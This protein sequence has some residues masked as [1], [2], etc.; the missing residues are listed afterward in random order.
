MRNN[1]FFQ[2]NISLLAI[3]HSQLA[4]I[5]NSLTITVPARIFPS[6][7]GRISAEIQTV[8][9]K[10][11]LLHSAF[12]PCEESSSWARQQNISANVFVLL[13]M[14]LGYPALALL[15]R[16]FSGKLAIVENDIDIFK[17]ALMSCDLEVLLSNE[18]ISFYVGR[19]IDGLLPHLRQAKAI[20]LSYGLFPPSYLLNSDFYEQISL[21]LDKIIYETKKMRDPQTC[22][23]LEE[24]LKEMAS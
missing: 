9:G 13:G 16:S 7:S 21:C 19:E 20:H 18:N 8:P 22:S 3:K 2:K 15:K 17:L 6:Q 10:S 11:L 1:V 24:A 14:G 4:K 5:L 23:I 12:D